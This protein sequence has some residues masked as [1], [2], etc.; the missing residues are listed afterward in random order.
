MSLW[1]ILFSK[2]AN[3]LTA[4]PYPHNMIVH[5]L[6][7]I[8]TCGSKPLREQANCCTLFLSFSHSF[9]SLSL[10]L[11]TSSTFV[12]WW[13][14]EQ[15]LMVTFDKLNAI[16][17]FS[18]C[19]HNIFPQICIVSCF[20]LSPLH[21]GFLVF[22]VLKIKGL[23]AK[24]R[25]IIIITLTSQMAGVSCLVNKRAPLNPFPLSSLCLRF[26]KETAIDLQT[27]E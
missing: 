14:L 26:S 18:G 24:E 21:F 16:M 27:L 13:P 3:L 20:P 11:S 1:I 17:L 7:S 25:E 22:R 8:V 10:P 5:L 9:F 23:M 2:L 6:I 19:N 4:Q 15:S 12:P